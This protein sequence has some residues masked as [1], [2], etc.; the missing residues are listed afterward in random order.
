MELKA[1]GEEDEEIKQML[2]RYF[3]SDLAGQVMDD[4]ISGK[5]YKKADILSYVNSGELKLTTEVY[6][7]IIAQVRTSN[8]DM[9]NLI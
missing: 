2:D 6:N 1:S 4:I 3:S 7:K 8:I 9:N 5:I